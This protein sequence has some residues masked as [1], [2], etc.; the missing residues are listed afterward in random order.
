MRPQ[1]RGCCLSRW[2]VPEDWR[3][4]DLFSVPGRRGEMRLTV[5]V[6]RAQCAEF[7]TQRHILSMKRGN[8]QTN[9]LIA[10]RAQGIG[11]HPELDFENTSKLSICAGNKNSGAVFSLTW[12]SLTSSSLF[13]PCRRPQSRLKNVSC[14]QRN[15]FARAMDISDKSMTHN[16]PNLNGLRL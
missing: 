5:V 2:A 9:A 6:A 14:S 13:E 15:L 7:L 12:K 16:F 1:C 4:Y 11:L 3:R 10:R 8:D